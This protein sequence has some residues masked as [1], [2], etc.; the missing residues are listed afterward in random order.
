MQNLKNILAEHPFL[1]NLNPDYLE[2]MAGCA[3]NVNFEA[4]QFIFHEGDKAGEFYL[5]RHGKIALQMHI[6]GRG[7]IT[8]QT[9]GEGEVLGWSWLLPPYKKQF[10]AY[11]LELTRA[12]ALNGACIIEKCEKDPKMGYEILKRFAAI[13]G[14]R[15][16][17]TRLQLLDIY[18]KQP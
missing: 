8:I 5:I 9:L 7:P 18:G 17:A 11:T 1:A 12:T 13:M 14:E 2:T 3:A 16:H 6:P 10:D 15:L 4:G